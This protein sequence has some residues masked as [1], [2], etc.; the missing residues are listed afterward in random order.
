MEVGLEPP[1]QAARFVG[2]VDGDGQDDV[3]PMS[4]CVT[5]T[6]TGASSSLL[7]AETSPILF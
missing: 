7:E 3:V 1:V 6:V 4:S 5:A 2:L